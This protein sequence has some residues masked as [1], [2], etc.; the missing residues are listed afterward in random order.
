M[1]AGA[2]FISHSAKFV[3]VKTSKSIIFEKLSGR[4][5]SKIEKKAIPFLILWMI[6]MLMSLMNVFSNC[7]TFLKVSLTAKYRLNPVNTK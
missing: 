2:I 5:D 4:L 3:W 7:V 6:S 1:F